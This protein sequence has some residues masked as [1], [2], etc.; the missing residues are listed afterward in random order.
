MA[1][2]VGLIAGCSVSREHANKYVAEGTGSINQVSRAIYAS[3]RSNPDSNQSAIDPYE[4]EFEEFRRGQTARLAVIEEEIKKTQLQLDLLLQGLSSLALEFLPGGS[5]ISQIVQAIGGRID[6]QAGGAL[7]KATEIE[8][9]LQGQID[10]INKALV[11]MKNDRTVDSLKVDQ[12][13]AD[14]I[15]TLNNIEDN[16]EKL[17]QDQQASLRQELAGQLSD[18]KALFK[19][20]LL[21]LGRERGLSE[22]ELKIIQDMSEEDV[23][24]KYGLEGGAGILGLLALIRTFGRSRSKE[25]VDA[26]REK[27][28]GLAQ[29]NT[30]VQTAQALAS[31]K[32]VFV[33]EEANQIAEKVASALKIN[34]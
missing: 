10:A 7:E 9:K 18:Q 20:E 33:D 17:N 26:L 3:A 11:A 25:E 28:E 8:E 22:E 12:A 34:Q 19:D 32:S 6:T 23:F 13:N 29:E 27:L 4:T 5:S 14:L 15:K 24:Q 30:K 1:L 21:K 31:S 16:A 2:T